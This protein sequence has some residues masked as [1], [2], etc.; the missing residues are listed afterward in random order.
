V[1]VIRTYSERKGASSAAKPT[2]TFEF[3]E[4][5]HCWGRAIKRTAGCVALVLGVALAILGVVAAFDISIGL[6]QS[7]C[8]SPLQISSR[9]GFLI[10]VAPI[11]YTARLWPLITTSAC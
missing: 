6:A 4:V 7:L 3:H 8:S 9:I 5:P 11:A 10:V 2:E 1:D